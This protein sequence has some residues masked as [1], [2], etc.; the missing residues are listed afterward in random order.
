MN[1]MIFKSKKFVI[2]IF[3]ILFLP[4]SLLSENLQDYWPTHGWRKDSPENRGMDSKKLIEM[5]QILK[6]YPIDSVTIVKDGYIVLDA[7]Q[8]PYQ[9]DRLHK[10]LSCT[11]SISASLIGIAIDNN[12]I[13][14][15][16]QPLLS[17]F[18]E[19]KIRVDG[20][21]KRGINLHH[22]LTMTT[23]IDFRDSYLYQWENLKKMHRTNNWVDFALNLPF[24]HE[25]G[26]HYD[27]SNITAFLLSAIIQET[28]GMKASEFAE[29][30]L[31]SK[32][33]IQEYIW[34]EN[35]KGITLGYGSLRMNNLDLA[36]LGLLYL[37]N[38]KWE[39]KQVISREWIKVSTSTQV[40]QVKGHYNYGYQWWVENDSLFSAQGKGG[41]DII[42]DHKHNLVVV[43]TSSLPDR[44]TDQP[45]NIYSTYIQPSIVS[46][47]K[48]PENPV[49][50]NEL[51]IQIRELAEPEYD[52]NKVNQIPVWFKKYT[53]KKFI[54]KHKI[55]KTK[56]I[57]FETNFKKNEIFLTEYD[58]ENKPTR[59][60]LGLA[61]QYF[62]NQL[63]PNVLTAAK[64][65]F[66]NNSI[67]VDIAS[68]EI[69]WR[70]TGTFRFS[71]NSVDVKVVDLNENKY[72]TQGFMIE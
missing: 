68:P 46:N 18:P 59:Y 15:V 21:R 67:I 48:I 3:L 42:I 35:R 19:E 29:K 4:G 55:F 11:K 49:A 6:S 9:A 32:L 31:F 25:P 16:E 14:G 33:G 8:H 54:Y 24:I 63:G 17:F 28:T 57:K 50:L 2:T 37:T 36:K 45:R 65:T 53:G 40:K 47:I 56:K 39:E 30:Y 71:E 22:A 20:Q 13:K 64:A 44:L 41:Q 27:Y 52:E 61:G 70:A 58:V 12:F 10:I 66:E 62:V 7:Y 72:F 60:K 26:T 1:R 34:P 69:A 5:L 38:G 43:F 23:G 51:N